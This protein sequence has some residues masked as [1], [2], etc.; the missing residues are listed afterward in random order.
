MTHQKQMVKHIVKW[1]LK[2]EALGQDKRTNALQIREMLYGLI[3]VVREIN[4]LEVVMDTSQE[5]GGHD[6][7]LYSVFDSM[8]ALEAYKVHP[9][10]KKVVDF[11]QNV[12]ETR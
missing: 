9:A 8:A 1:N 4:F 5:E 3:G 10:H 7:V 2:E 11:V 6:V 12:V